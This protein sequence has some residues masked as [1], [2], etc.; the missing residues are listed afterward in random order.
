MRTID[1]EDDVF[2]ELERASYLTKIPV[3]QILRGLVIRQPL[4]A[5]RVSE[6][7]HTA[8]T[9][10][11]APRDKK[12]RDYSQSPGF[13]AS[14]SVVDQFLSLLSFLY[15]ENPDK[16][17]VLE[18]ME[19]RRR[20]YVAKT[21]QELDDSGRSVNAKRIPSTNYWVVTNNSTDNKKLLIRQVLTLLGYSQETVRLVPDCLR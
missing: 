8:T 7:P 3:D 15:K 21:E 10:P 6:S 14:R 9:N 12:L 16:F 17:E 19:G 4:A 5:T 11:P 1:V 18:S 13:L 2:S 20:K